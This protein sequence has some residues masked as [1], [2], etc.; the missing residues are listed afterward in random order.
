MKNI[1]KT[2]TWHH[3][4]SLWGWC[5]QVMIGVAFAPDIA[6]SLMV[7]RLH[8]SLIWPEYLLSYVWGVTHKP[9]GEHQTCLL[10]FF[11]KQWLFFWPLFRKTQLCGVY[12]LKWS[13]GQILQS[14]LWSFASRS[15]LSLV[16]L[17]PLWLMPSLPGLW[18][19]V[20]SPLL[21]GLLWCNILSIFE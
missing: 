2:W 4:T 5:S 1:P 19:L 9:S 14:P 13:Y 7:K 8:F 11:F 10:I 20:G 15:G 6:F 3:H 16:S 17:L 21:A 12:G 18:V